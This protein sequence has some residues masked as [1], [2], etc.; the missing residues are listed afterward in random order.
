[1]VFKTHKL[2][3]SSFTE[4]V[5]H[6]YIDNILI[7]FAQKEKPKKQVTNKNILDGKDNRGIC[8]L[9][10]SHFNG[11]TYTLTHIFIFRSLRQF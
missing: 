1:M 11:I 3:I 2:F 7:A 8:Y 10:S 6:L 9:T 4:L 5:C